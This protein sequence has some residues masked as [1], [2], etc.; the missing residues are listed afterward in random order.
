MNSKNLRA[1]IFGIV[2]GA[3]FVTASPTFAQPSSGPNSDQASSY[4]LIPGAMRGIRTMGPTGYRRL[5]S[6]MSVGLYEWR[7]RWVERFIKPSG[8]QRSALNDLVTASAKSKEL[9]TAACPRVTVETTTAQL[10]VMEKRVGAVLEALKII[11]PAYETFY[12]SLDTKQ[13]AILDA[14]GPGR[15]GWRW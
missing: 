12:T 13:K 14:I 3:A 8:A 4:V 10:E 15:R 11:R 2:C 9:I 7:V 5:C 1:A 6:P